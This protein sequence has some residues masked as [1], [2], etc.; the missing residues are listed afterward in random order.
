MQRFAPPWPARA[1]HTGA[2]LW[3]TEHHPFAG[4]FRKPKRHAAL[5]A[6]PR[7]HTDLNP[8]HTT[9]THQD[10]YRS[11]PVKALLRVL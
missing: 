4:V 8:H 9:R 3:H 1:C 5:T 7:D 6:A 2:P 11:T 10:R